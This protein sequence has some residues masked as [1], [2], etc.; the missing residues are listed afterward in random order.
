L[1]EVFLNE[2]F[3]REHID[4]RRQHETLIALLCHKGSRNEARD[5]L[6]VEAVITQPDD[7]LRNRKTQSRHASHRIAHWH[8]FAN[9]SVR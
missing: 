7:S 2:N 8:F 5:T 3:P 4:Q 1:T 9:L 6:P